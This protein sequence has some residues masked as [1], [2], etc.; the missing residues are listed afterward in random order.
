MYY[1]DL[2]MTVDGILKGDNMEYEWEIVI[3]AIERHI[4]VRK[5]GKGNAEQ[6]LEFLDDLQDEIQ[7]IKVDLQAV[8]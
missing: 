4:L 3:G 7:D 8:K 5:K 1:S 2:L 6:L